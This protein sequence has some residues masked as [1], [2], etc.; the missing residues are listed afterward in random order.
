MSVAEAKAAAAEAALAHVDDGM[1]VGL[2]T[3]S[4]AAAFIDQLAGAVA[5]GLAVT[6]VP[7]SLETE[8]RAREQGIPITPLATVDRVDLA[9]DGADQ[10]TSGGV[11]I[12]GGGGAVLRERLVADMA[13]EFVVIVDST[14]LTTVLD[15]P[16]PVVIAPAARGVIRRR[17]EEAGAVPRLRT[18][19][20]RLGPTLT[21]DH[22]MIIDADFGDIDDPDRCA[23][24]IAAIEGV[25]A[26]GLWPTLCDLLI[27]ADQGG[28]VTE[29]SLGDDAQ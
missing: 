20:G 13:A 1:V 27:A 2:G 15:H 14:K 5:D 6:G 7:T 17:L 24:T 11:L 23:A 9:V 8:R 28:T 25:L 26:H 16:V 3:G 22:A 12:K 29:T 19:D 18:G 10:V 21:D 4:T